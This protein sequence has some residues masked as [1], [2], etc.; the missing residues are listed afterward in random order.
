MG[1]ADGEGEGR[2]DRDRLEA[3]GLIR[4]TRLHQTPRLVTARG[5][6]WCAQWQRRGRTRWRSSW[7]SISGT[8]QG[9]AV[10]ALRQ[11]I[12]DALVDAVEC[13]QRLEAAERAASGLLAGR[14]AEVAVADRGAH[15]DLTAPPAL[16]SASG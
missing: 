10:A 16:R 9:S 1:Q 13:R 6:A 2:P 12:S 4:A 15:H 11:A 7:S 14:P 5:R 3:A 8:S